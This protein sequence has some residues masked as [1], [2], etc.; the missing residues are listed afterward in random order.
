MVFDGESERPYRPD[1]E[2][3]PISQYGH[4]KLLGEREVLLRERPDFWIVRSG[5]VFGPDGSNFPRAILDRAR[6]GEALR[7]VDDQ[8]GSPTLTLDLAE[9]LLDLATARPEAG[10]YHACN[11]GACSWHRFACD[12]LDAAGIQA[13]VARIKSSE[14]DRPAPRPRYSVLDCTNMTELRGQPLPY[15]KDAIERYLR[16]TRDNQQ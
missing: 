10:I 8:T 15:Y 4:S 16:A 5:W 11:R 3:N 2:P 7:V 13:D 14:L 1:D 6:S 9:A 12:I